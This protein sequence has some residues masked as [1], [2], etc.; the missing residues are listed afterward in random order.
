MT[1]GNHDPGLAPPIML[2]VVDEMGTDLLES[3]WWV[4]LVSMVLEG[5]VLMKLG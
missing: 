2:A 3:V 1:V 5:V 4:T